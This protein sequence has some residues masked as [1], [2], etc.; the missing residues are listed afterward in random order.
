MSRVVTEEEL[1]STIKH[2]K[3][4]LLVEP[5]YT[6]K[7]IPLGL[8]KIATAIKDNG[9]TVHYS[10][11]WE[12]DKYDTIFVTSLFTY[13]SEKVHSVIPP[14]AHMIFPHTPM[15]LGGI[16]A[17]LMPEYI[18]SKMDVNLFKGCSDFLDNC[19]PDY[20][21]NWGV[22]HPWDKFSYCFTSR[23]CPN[24]CP[25]C[26][27][28][29]IEPEL[30]INKEWKKHISMDLP[31]VMI[32]DNNPS[33]QPIEHLEDIVRF[34]CD[35]KK[36]VLFNNGFDCKYITPD[37]V[38][39]LA[40][41]KFFQGGMRL[42][43]DRI[44]EDGIFQDAVELLL[45]AKVY[46]NNILSFVLFN[47]TDTP[48]EANYRM[49]ECVRLGI[50]PYPQQYTPLNQL[51]C[52]NKFIG[53]YWTENLVRCFRFF[54]LMAGYYTKMTFMEFIQSNDKYK[55]SD[56]DLEKWHYSRKGHS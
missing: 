14:I 52:K 10:R 30:K 22:S 29:K 56:I 1:V 45:K 28:W 39:L 47:F 44:E 38:K 2:T 11:R 7:Y 55:L 12:P 37:I 15:Y 33:A 24:R 3:K 31:Y 9:G 27:V 20:T 32:S 19:S 49:T 21:I 35:N 54:W 26:A 43:F 6:N 40:K 16:Y 18:L 8:A 23:G 13:E 53:K 25:Y 4:A 48:Q 41:L 42:A 17:S 46:K 50:R 51:S 5:P 36:P 34:L